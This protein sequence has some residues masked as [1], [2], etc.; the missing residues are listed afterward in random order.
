MRQFKIAV[1]KNTD[2]YV[3]YPLGLSGIVVGQCETY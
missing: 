2:R 3:A 1:E